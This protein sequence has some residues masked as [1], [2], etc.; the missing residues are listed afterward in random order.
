MTLT[1]GNT[2]HCSITADSSLPVASITITIKTPI[3]IDNIEHTI[4]SIKAELNIEESLFSYE[5][6]ISG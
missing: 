5:K 1:L 3:N 2:H 6:K 4:N